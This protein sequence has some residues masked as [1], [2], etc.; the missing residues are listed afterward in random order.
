MECIGGVQR[1][2]EAKAMLTRPKRER[3]SCGAG[4]PAVDEED[5]FVRKGIHLKGRLV[6]ALAAALALLALVA[7]GSDDDAD[8]VPQS[9]AAAADTARRAEPTPAPTVAPEA[10][11]APEA[12]AEPT[13][14]PGLAAECLPGGALQDAETITSCAEQAL[15]QVTG[16]SFRGR[17]QPLRPLLRVRAGRPGTRSRRSPHAAQRRHRPRRTGCRS[18]YPSDPQARRS[19]VAVIV[20]GQDT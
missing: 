7:C 2:L 5:R 20:I 9:P 6:P 10:T 18:R 13:A 1:S 3:T 12:P 11:A 16:F 14:P 17:V 19:Q 8:L 4:A 15:R